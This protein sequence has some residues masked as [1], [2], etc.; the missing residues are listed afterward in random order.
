M[1]SEKPKR[2]GSPIRFIWHKARS[3]PIPFSYE[4]QGTLEH[5]VQTLQGFRP[6]QYTSFDV[7][8]NPSSQEWPEYAF[9]LKASDD[10]VGRVISTSETT[11]VLEGTITVL[12]WPFYM[13]LVMLLIG[14]PSVFFF[15][16][17]SCAFPF[18]LFWLY[19][20]YSTRPR[21]NYHHILELLEATVRGIESTP[22]LYKPPLK[23]NPH[24]TPKHSRPTKPETDEDLEQ[25][26]R[27]RS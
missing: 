22:P 25:Q 5:V 21:K 13:V 10:A 23:I 26:K 27:K 20:L 8:M 16:G 12:L 4:V 2:K 7:D 14:T 18:L 1:M 3:H 24:L 11:S 15:L 9:T 19:C 17:Q 6:D